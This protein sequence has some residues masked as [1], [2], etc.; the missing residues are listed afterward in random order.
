[1]L[2]QTKPEDKGESLKRRSGS[3]AASRG[4]WAVSNPLKGGFWGEL[5]SSPNSKMVA[6]VVCSLKTNTGVY[7]NALHSCFYLIFVLW[8]N[9]VHILRA[10]SMELYDWTMELLLCIAWEH[11]YGHLV[12]AIHLDVR[13]SPLVTLVRT[14]GS[15]QWCS[16]LSAPGMLL[17]C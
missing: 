13:V 4:F 8:G 11:L 9:L 15:Q 10:F 16:T 7:W 1:M 17:A 12:H 14:R 6:L 2:N 3:G 5:S